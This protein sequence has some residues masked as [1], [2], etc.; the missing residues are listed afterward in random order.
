MPIVA[1]PD[2]SLGF[3]LP[4]NIIKEANIKMAPSSIPTTLGMMWPPVVATPL[5]R[6]TKKFMVAYTEI[7]KTMT[8]RMHAIYAFNFF[9]SSSSQRTASNPYH[10]TIR[11]TCSA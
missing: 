5:S 10:L 1:S 4:L 11:L 6:A 9:K 8:P 3:S 2:S 7:N